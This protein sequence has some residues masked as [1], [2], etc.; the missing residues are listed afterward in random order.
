M[1]SPGPVAFRSDETTTPDVRA[2]PRE[3]ARLRNQEKTTRILNIP[4]AS[5]DRLRPHSIETKS[6]GEP[7]LPSQT[8]L[9]Q[10]GAIHLL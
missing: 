3:Q 7:L 4:T 8:E 6:R 5:P 2:N 1:L 10:L 9:R